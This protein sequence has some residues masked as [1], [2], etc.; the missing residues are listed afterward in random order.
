MSNLKIYHADD[1]SFIINPKDDKVFCEFYLNS[2]F[3]K[4]LHTVILIYDNHERFRAHRMNLARMFPPPRSEEIILSDGRVV[5]ASKN[6][7]MDKYK[8]IHGFYWS[9]RLMSHDKSR[10]Y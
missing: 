9:L 6:P 2:K 4:H 3:H 10:W 8:V 1:E 5:F 7:Q